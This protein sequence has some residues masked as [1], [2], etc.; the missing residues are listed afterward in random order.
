MKL[1]VLRRSDSAPAP[2]GP[3][4]PWRSWLRQLR[5]RPLRAML[6]RNQGLKL[7]AL[8]TAF[9]LWAVINA[10]ERD[11]ERVIELPVSVRKV[12]A[13]LLVVNPPAKPVVLTLRGPR[14]I[15][16]G[17]DEH[18]AR[19]VDEVPAVRDPLDRRRRRRILA[20]LLAQARARE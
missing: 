5:P 4:V 14:S 9:F 15:L 11:A 8:I 17:I 13:G 19:P 7:A 6:R 10:T 2:Q 12:P 3:W 20:G 1:S 16:D 18:R